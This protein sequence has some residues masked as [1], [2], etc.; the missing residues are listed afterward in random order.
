MTTYS[1]GGD[2]VD[3]MDEIYRQYAAVV[4]RYLLS[5]THDPNLAEELTQ[6]TFFQAIRSTDRFEGKSSVSTWLCGIAKNC[7][8]AYRRKH[9]DM[10]DIEDQ[11]LY[12]PSAETDAIS[13]DGKN[14]LLRQLH[15][16]PEPQREVVYLRVLGDLSFKEIGEIFDRSENWAR[17]TFFRARERLKKEVDKDG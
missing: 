3:S 12:V 8:R 10:Q 14:S 11:K 13:I 17:V 1:K 5:V 16:L 9:P 4:Y 15:R 7:L 6:E 2:G